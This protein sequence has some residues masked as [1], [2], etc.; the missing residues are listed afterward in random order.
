M[1]FPNTGIHPPPR[2]PDG[3][4]PPESCTL[5]DPTQ[6]SRRGACVTPRTERLVQQIEA[7]R[8]GDNGIACWDP[9]AWNPTSDHPKGRACDVT[10]G[11]LGKFPKG[12]DKENGDRLAEW[13]VSNADTWGISYVIWQGRVWSTARAGQGWR[14]YTG[15]GIY[16][17]SDPTGGHFDHIHV[18]LK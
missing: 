16:D 4:W 14:P 11:S 2:N 5:K 1:F 12:A 3:T 8:V 17:P 13:L 10:F 18:S 15:G 7:M 6:P 9:H